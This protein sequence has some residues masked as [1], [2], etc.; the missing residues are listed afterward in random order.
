M[1]GTTPSSP[2]D[3]SQGLRNDPS[4]HDDVW[5]IPS[6]GEIP[7]WL[8]DADMRDGIRALH[9]ADRCVEESNR[10]RPEIENMSRWLKEE[11][12]VEYSHYLFVTWAPALSPS[13]GPSISHPVEASSSLRNPTITANILSPHV[14]SP[15]LPDN[16]DEEDLD[17]HGAILDLGARRVEAAEE[18]DPGD[19]SES[20]E[21]VEVQDNMNDDDDERDT[22]GLNTDHLNLTFEWD[23]VVLSVILSVLRGY[24]NTGVSEVQMGQVAQADWIGKMGTLRGKIYG[25]G[26]RDNGYF[27]NYLW[28]IHQTLPPRQQG[29]HL[30]TEFSHTDLP[31]P[32]LEI[33]TP[34]RIVII[35]FTQSDTFIGVVREGGLLRPASEALVMGATKRLLEEM[36]GF[37]KWKLLELDDACRESG[38]GGD[39]ACGT[40]TTFPSRSLQVSS[41][42]ST[43]TNDFGTNRGQ[44]I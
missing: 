2:I 43:R 19:T 42:I 1:P 3:R 13:P 28:R 33:S 4:L 38:E 27:K 18:L 8:D 9:S 34:C 29:S 12:T 44:F 37:R 23:T 36:L 41:S 25:G 11:N 20:E 40:G 39:T 5:I 21:G 14:T 6:E 16:I 7:R 31:A 15:L 24:A 22:T 35:L 26:H 30:I 17:D 32:V 10:I